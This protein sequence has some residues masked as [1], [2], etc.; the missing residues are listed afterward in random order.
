MN[1][2]MEQMEQMKT[3]DVY[4]EVS[5]DTVDQETLHNA[6]DSRW[7]HKNK[8][9]TE[10]RSR[11]VAKGYKEEVE[12][13]DDIYA[14]APFFDM[15]G[16]EKVATEAL[17][18][19]VR[20]YVPLT[21]EEYTYMVDHTTAPL[22]TTIQAAERMPLYNRINGLLEQSHCYPFMAYMYSN[23]N[24][25]TATKDGFYILETFVSQHA[26]HA[27]VEDSTRFFLADH[28]SPTLAFDYN[29]EFSAQEKQL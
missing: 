27:H 24:V 1:K 22:V 17:S 29:Y 12:D 9:P 11:I 21:V 26:L 13:L 8:T 2:D 16:G 18:T 5:T 15:T 19:H 23:S 10:V 4:E 25:Y 6:I 28:L 20:Y 14:S 3:H 7:A